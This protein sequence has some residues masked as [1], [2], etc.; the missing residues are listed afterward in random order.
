MA[1]GTELQYTKLEEF[2]LDPMNPRLGR[3][4]M[5]RDVLQDKVLD[6]VRDFA[7]DE[8]AI[9][10]LESGSFWTHEALLVTKEE[11]YGETQLVVIEGNRRIAALKYLYNAYEGNPFSSKWRRIAES[12]EPPPKL[13]TR[14]P[15][16]LV[17]SREE[18]ESFLGFR[19]VTGIKE[20]N[21]AEKAQFI[22]KLIDE[23]GM[24]YEQVMRRIG[25]KTPSVR[26]NYIS[27][28][29]LL[30]MEDS[31]EGFSSQSAEKRFSVMYL[32]LRAKGIQ[33]Y[34]Q[35]DIEADPDAVKRPVPEEH[36]EALGK[37]ALWLFGDDKSP[38][39]F[40][41]SRKVDHFNCILQS[42]KA[43][44]YLERTE[45]PNFDVA[46]RMAGGDEPEI[47]ELI[48]AAADNIERILSIVHLHKKSSKIQRAV[49][50]L[51]AHIRQL[52]SIFP[53]IQKKLEEDED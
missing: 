26:R 27:Y 9:S 30:Q 45:R 48:E 51:G 43:T 13:F 46:Y 38:P 42:S 50:R 40:T 53:S 32:S 16:I 49:A 37:F 47:V 39:L 20:W 52:L 12:A 8:L 25:S 31:V 44:K 11:L 5:G 1:I 15:Y 17:D 36:L 35:I 41:D 29:L 10:Y 7:L 18:I 28:R 3:N 33:Q 19:H 34:L 23:R 22:A 6:L 4:N 2:C 24:T 14:I 21:P